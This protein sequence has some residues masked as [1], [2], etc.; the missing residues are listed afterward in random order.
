MDTNLETVLDREDFKALAANLK[1]SA[2]L[3]PDVAWNQEDPAWATIA[4]EGAKAATDEDL[5]G[6]R[7]SCKAC[8]RAFRKRYKSEFRT[9]PLP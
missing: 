1:K 3:V 5:A 8:H 7:A 6:T 4:M 2:H 9:R